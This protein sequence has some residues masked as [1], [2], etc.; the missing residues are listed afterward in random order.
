MKTIYLI[1]LIA[2]AAAAGCSGKKTPAAELINQQASLP[3]NLPYDPFQ[4][5][6]ITSGLNN[7]ESTMFTL[8][9]NDAAVE[10]ARTNAQY[11]YPPDSVLCLVTWSRKEDKHWFGG[12]IPAEIKSIE[13]VKV[14]ATPPY[15]YEVYEGT[16]PVK[17]ETEA[18]AGS[19]RVNSIL[20]MRASVMP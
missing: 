18:S 3:G 11:S 16:P 12:E 7:H 8:Y 20:G 9:G 5:R 13:F 4:W 1:V 14:T 6:V 19:D 15:T 17:K 10:Y 2:C